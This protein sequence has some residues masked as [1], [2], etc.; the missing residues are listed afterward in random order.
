MCSEVWVKLAK[1]INEKNISSSS[2]SSFQCKVG[3]LVLYWLGVLA[4]NTLYN[5]QVTFK[6]KYILAF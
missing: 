3:M 6:I 1:E 4:K 2:L 5:F